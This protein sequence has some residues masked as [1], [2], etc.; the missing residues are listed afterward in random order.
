MPGGALKSYFDAIKLGEE[1]TIGKGYSFFAIGKVMNKEGTAICL[2]TTSGENSVKPYGVMT[3]TMEN[4]WY[5]HEGQGYFQK[6]SQEK[7]F[8]IVKDY[9]K[10]ASNSNRNICKAKSC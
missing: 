9:E 7:Y 1:V 5:I 10:M 3:K 8:T 4:G 2:K 6:E